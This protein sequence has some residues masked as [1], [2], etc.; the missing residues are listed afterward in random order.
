[1]VQYVHANVGL[2][3]GAGRRMARDI[4]Q[5]GG[6]L[7]EWGCIGKEWTYYW[8]KIRGSQLI[9]MKVLEISGV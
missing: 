4:V 3:I 8:P 1:M 7:M 9:F 6:I 5:S 2:R